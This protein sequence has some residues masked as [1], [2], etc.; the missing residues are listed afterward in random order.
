MFPS[1]CLLSYWHLTYITTHRRGDCLTLYTNHTS[2]LRSHPKLAHLASIGQTSSRLRASRVPFNFLVQWGQSL[3]EHSVVILGHLT[4]FTSLKA[5]I[6]RLLGNLHSVMSVRHKASWNVTARDLEMEER[7]MQ[8][9]WT[10]RLGWLHCFNAAIPEMT[11]DL[12]QNGQPSCQGPQKQRGGATK[13]RR[14][15]MS[16]A[17]PADRVGRLCS[18][19]SR[20]RNTCGERNDIGPR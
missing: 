2:S 17:K 5:Y 15:D 6:D 10:N 8:V 12:A 9:S 7:Y 1:C 4:H 16:E 14:R 20:W 11:L 18:V 19:V 3:D 13:T